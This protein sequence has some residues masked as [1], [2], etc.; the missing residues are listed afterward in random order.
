MSFGLPWYNH[1]HQP[2]CNPV[3]S[4]VP[5]ADLLEENVP[6]LW[7]LWLSYVL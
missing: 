6:P 1:T 5:S 3:A 2:I 7:E 4:P